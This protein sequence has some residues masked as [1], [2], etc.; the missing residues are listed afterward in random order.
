MSKRGVSSNAPP[1]KK[2]KTGGGGQDISASV[3]ET[4]EMR[5]KLGMKP[6]DMNKKVDKESPRDVDKVSTADDDAQESRQLKA[7]D[8]AKKTHDKL[9][10]GKGLG[11]IIADEEKGG[12]SDWVARM[13]TGGAQEKNAA[14]MKEDSKKAASKKEADVSGLK[15][16]HDVSELPEDGGEVTMTLSDKR[17]LDDNGELIEGGDE[18]SNN[19]L[20]ELQ[21]ARRGDKIK[22][23]KEYDPDNAKDIL[24]KYDEIPKG[25]SG[26]TLGSGISSEMNPEEKLQMLTEKAKEQSAMGG[27]LKFQSDYYTSEQMAEFKKPPKKAKKTKKKAPTDSK[28]EDMPK[29]QKGAAAA[30]AAANQDSDEEDP[31]LYEQLSKQRRLVRSTTTGV[32]KKG[33]AALTNVQ[34][35]VQKVSDEKEKEEIKKE[36]DAK[37]ASEKINM[38][39]TTEFC[40]VVQTPLEK[41][42]TI[43][44]ESFRGGTM[45]K[46]QVTKRKGVKAGHAKSSGAKKG[47]MPVDMDE[48]EENRDDDAMIE[49]G[50]DLTAASGLAY[51]RARAQ[52]GKDQE[53]HGNKKSDNRPLEMS[54]VDGDIKLEYRDDYGRVQTPKEAFRAISWKFHGKMPGKKNLERRLL[55]LENEVKLKSMNVMEQLP[56]L[57]ALRHVQTSD[58]KPYM[59]LS[60]ANEK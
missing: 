21:R 24:E 6:L 7:A 16:S 11:D 4:N 46:T 20:A 12:A 39:A 1:A 30:A 58:A 54:L 14:K 41:L 19:R 33:E 27:D 31:E 38:T 22:A 17:L 42:E 53:S 59:V 37:K 8:R 3:D 50:L 2:G 28:N 47:A 32:R 34:A 44:H 40:N 51:L 36:E 48:E 29:A 35:E 43:K 45:Y 18:L 25:V 49:D 23:Q 5:A 60:G 52:I 13:R 56:T 26:F 9:V 15:V 55:R 57:R 10:S